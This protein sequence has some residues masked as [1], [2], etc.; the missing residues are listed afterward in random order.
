MVDKDLVS[1][2]GLMLPRVAEATVLRV[3]RPTFSASKEAL[4]F[5]S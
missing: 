4:F 2:F 1:K 3:M 5:L